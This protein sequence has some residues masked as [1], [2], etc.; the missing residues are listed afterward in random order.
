MVSF[1]SKKEPMF[2]H[3]APTLKRWFLA[4]VLAGEAS[5]VAAARDAVERNVLQD[6]RERRVEWLPGRRHRRPSTAPYRSP[7]NP[8][9]AGSR[10]VGGVYGE[11]VRSEGNRCFSY[12]S[13]D[14]QIL[15]LSTDEHVSWM[16]SSPS[17]R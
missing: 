7:I 2:A 13:A 15:F 12:A 4:R 17:D 8:G 1:P 16:V 14:A 3:Y 11:R 6:P 10:G 5:N 9:G